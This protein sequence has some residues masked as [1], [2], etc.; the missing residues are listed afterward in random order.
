MVDPVTKQPRTK[1]LAN[2]GRQSKTMLTVNG[3]IKLVRRWYS[4][5][6]LGSVAPADEWADARQASMT[7]GVREMACRLNNDGVSFDTTAGNLQRTALVKM[8]GEQLRQTVLKE[9]QTV[10]ES[11]RTNAIPTAFQATDCVVD[12]KV[13]K[14][15][16]K[17]RL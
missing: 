15:E 5:G 11:Q 12:P 14:A 13:P 9:G 1:R 8:C 4:G 17:T 7:I 3:R 6:T 10:L 16:Q 2:K